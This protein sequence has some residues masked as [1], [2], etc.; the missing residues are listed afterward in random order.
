MQTFIICFV[1]NAHVG[2]GS[3]VMMMMIT[4]CR[5]WICPCRNSMLIAPNGLHPQHTSCR[6]LT[7]AKS[8]SLM[9]LFNHDGG[10]GGGGLGTGNNFKAIFNSQFICFKDSTYVF[11]CHK[12]V[13][14]FV[15]NLSSLTDKNVREREREKKSMQQSSPRI[16][17]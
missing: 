8:T 11:S 3:T 2:K 5:A 14:W 15:P 13:P 10:G 6:F 17:Y 12:S 9:S 4:V 16:C 7:G 1:V